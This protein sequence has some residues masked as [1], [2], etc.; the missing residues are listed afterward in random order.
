MTK[1]VC[2]VNAVSKL[3][4]KKHFLIALILIPVLSGL[5][6]VASLQARRKPIAETKPQV[7]QVYS[8]KVETI[9]GSIRVKDC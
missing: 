3:T 7:H 9:K 2:K 6:S 8:Q 1:R 4:M 5:A